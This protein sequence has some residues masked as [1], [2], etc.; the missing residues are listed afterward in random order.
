VLV[1]GCA[2][3]PRGNR[4]SLVVNLRVRQS[5]GGA[6]VLND[7]RIRRPPVRL[8]LALLIG[9]VAA[10]CAV[11]SSPAGPSEAGPG[12]GPTAI[13]SL[14]DSFISGEAG[15]WNGNSLNLFG[16]R[17]GTDRAARCTFGIFCSYDAAR[18][19]GP[20]ASNGCHRSDVATIKSAAVAVTE[21]INLA[22]SGAKSVNIWRTSQGGQS[23]KGEAPQADQLL[24]VAQQKNVKLVV[25][26]ILANDVGF[27]DHVIACASRWVLGLGP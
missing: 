10:L 6:S 17:D 8:P 3:T 25:L 22:C 23:F 26:T 20:T 19:Y 14:G 18:V 1:G 16:T 24:T 27:A 4:R 5:E 15:R 9:V 12:T 7:F 2:L 13:V 21:K 11:F